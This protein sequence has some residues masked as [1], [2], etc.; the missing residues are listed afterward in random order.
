[1]KLQICLRTVSFE[2]TG[3]F[4]CFHT[5][6]VAVNRKSIQSFFCPPVG[7]LGI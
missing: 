1:M 3:D 4:F 5:R 7:W 2:P 6:R